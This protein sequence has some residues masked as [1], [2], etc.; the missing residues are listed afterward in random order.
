MKILAFTSDKKQLQAWLVSVVAACSSQDK[1]ASYWFHPGSNGFG[2]VIV[3]GAGSTGEFHLHSDGRVTA[4]VEDDKGTIS[5]ERRQVT[6]VHEFEERFQ[7]F[8]SKL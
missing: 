7:D 8:M 4:H 1:D 6:H 5:D 2:L 3:D